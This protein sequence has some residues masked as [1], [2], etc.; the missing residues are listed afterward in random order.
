MRIYFDYYV[1][2][3]SGSNTNALADS[4]FSGLSYLSSVS[5]GRM[6]TNF[7]NIPVT[8]LT[9]ENMNAVGRN[10][11]REYTVACCMQILALI[12][13]K[14][15]SIPI[16]GGELVPMNYGDLLSIS[17]PMMQKLEDDLR[18]ELAKLDL[19]EIARKESEKATY[20]MNILTM[21]S[22]M[23][24]FKYVWFIYFMLKMFTLC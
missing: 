15:Q 1:D 6:A 8:D 3:Q 16:P 18:A 17:S 20:Q 22:V 13:G 11:V 7:G 24:I 10:F 9:Y 21:T 2:L 19:Y 14:Y 12:R 4:S 5:A 23:P